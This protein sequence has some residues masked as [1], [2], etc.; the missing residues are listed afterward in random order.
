MYKGKEYI[1]KE[2]ECIK[3][4]SN[5]AFLFPV[6]SQVEKPAK[7]IKNP[8]NRKLGNLCPIFRKPHNDP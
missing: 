3:D 4:I 2:G 8:E 7:T 1:K 6:V 5:L